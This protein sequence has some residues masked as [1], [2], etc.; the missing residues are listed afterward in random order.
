MQN[1]Y[2][3]PQ[4]IITKLLNSNQIIFPPTPIASEFASK[5]VYSTDTVLQPV[6][7]TSMS[8]NL[9]LQHQS[10]AR[11]DSLSPNYSQTVVS[12]ETSHPGTSTQSKIPFKTVEPPQAGLL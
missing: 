3:L 4:D 12:T 6:I 2:L 1:I 9:S 8:E 7:Q 10:A 5:T 11:N